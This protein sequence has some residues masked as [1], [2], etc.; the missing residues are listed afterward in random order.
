[1]FTA[2]T[3][4]VIV[5][6]PAIPAAQAAPLSQ[7]PIISNNM[8]GSDQRNAGAKW[9][10]T[11]RDYARSSAVVLLQEAGPTP[12]GNSD[13]VENIEWD[14]QRPGR[15]GYV[16]HHTWQLDSDRNDPN[17]Y[18]VYFLQTDPMNG[19]WEGGRVNLA[20]VTRHQAEEVQVLR[21]F[22]AAPDARP[23]LG[24]RFGNTWYYTF[25][26]LSG[27]GADAASMVRDVAATATNAGEHFVMGGDFNTDPDV[28]QTRVNYP[29]GQVRRFTTGLATHQNGEE[30][31]YFIGDNGT[32]AQQRAQ[33]FNGASPDHYAVGIGPFRS[34]QTQT[35]ID[36]MPTGDAM[37]RGGNGSVFYNYRRPL[38]E[39]MEKYNYIHVQRS[40]GRQMSAAVAAADDEMVRLAPSLDMVGTQRDGDMPDPDHEGYPE[41]E[42]DQIAERVDDTVAQL[43]PNVVTL[44]AGTEDVAHD[45]DAAGAPGRLGRL[46]DQIIEDAPDATVLVATLPPAAHPAIQARI[47]EF[48]QRVPEVVAQRR[49]AGEHVSLVLMSHLSTDDLSDDGLYPNETGQRKMASAFVDGIVDAFL[50]GWITTDSGT[51]TEETADTLRPMG[52]GSSSTYGEGSSDGN[53]YRDSADQGFSQLADRNAEKTGRSGGSSLAGKRAASAVDDTPRVDWV[54]SV[55][56]GKMADREVEGWRGLRIHEI[57]NKATCAVKTY[58]P[59][60]ITLIA[61]GNDVMQKYQLDGAI[62]RLESLI[63]QVAFDDPG[64]AVLVAGMQPFRDPADDP[65]RNARGQAFTAQIPAMVDRLV[66][67]GLRVVYA[68]TT[69]LTLSDIGHDGIHPTDGGYDKIAAAFVKAAGQANDRGW[70][71]R[72]R[73]QAPDAGSDP[74]GMRDD[75]DGIGTGG[76][77]PNKLGQGWEDRGVIQA[78]QYPSSS[79]FWMVDINKDRKAE[80]VAVDKDQNFRFWWNSGPSGKDWTPFVEGQNSYKPKAGAVGNMLRFGD[81]DGDGFPDCMVVWLTGTVEVSTWKA[82]NPSGS[83]MCMNKY[84]G[85]ASVFDEGSRGE[86]LYTDPSTKIRFADVTG[87]GRDD[88]LLIK[89]DG[90]TTAWYNRDFQTKDGRKWLDWAPPAKIGGALANPRE[91][92]YADINGDKRAD[93]I[94]ITAKGGA[95]AWINDG[96]TG[97]GGAY[98]DIGR[99]AGDADVPPKDVQFADVDGDGKADFL[100]IGWTGV[101]HAWLNKLP[102]NYFGTFHP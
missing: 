30:Y 61:G 7:T 87:G 77:D 51:E 83:R 86:I 52:L 15:A 93:R 8:Q 12:P 88:Y 24:V 38:Y 54:G 10:T 75:G 34:Q 97:A 65:G 37:T 16:Q 50:A 64:V 85:E 29:R 89:P 95:R 57:A 63:E 4:T 23:T 9:T 33:R 47:E 14:P 91:I 78:R 68:D 49:A 62:G 11:V 70:L 72:A 56:V 76:S 13:F 73:P 94:L 42:I 84:G 101:T 36:L 46:I 31:D 5:T 80:F 98:R 26:A 79:R 43:R 100:R 40:R 58:Q 96:A 2:L 71:R 66:G 82:D 53:G 60:L 21:N 74:C 32:F 18:H 39:E 48:N 69:A 45:V 59:N 81:V 1:M 90:T 19:R 3:A 22:H 102:A 28:L 20:I 44:L 6:D 41:H 92:R 25:H 27:G 67:R 17:V 35:R 55:R 99:I